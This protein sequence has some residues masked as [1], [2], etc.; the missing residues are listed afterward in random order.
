MANT[1]R[2]GSTV[3]RGACAVELEAPAPYTYMQQVAALDLAALWKRIEAPALIFYGTAD[4]VTDASQHEYLRDMINS[5]HPGQATYVVV[6][7]MDH[8]LTLTGTQ[9]AS[10]PNMQTR[11]ELYDLLGYDPSAG[12]V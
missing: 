1:L 2:P 7:G 3:F 4:F 6:D 5:F 8:G 11:Q 10:L 12:A 9:K